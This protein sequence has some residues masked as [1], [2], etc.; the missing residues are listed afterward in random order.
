MAR[1][2]SLCQCPEMVVVPAGSFTMG[3]PESEKDRHHE[4]GPQH[5]VT[6][7]KSFAVGRCAV[8]FDEWDA[9]VGDGGCIGYKPGDE[10]W[11]RDR[12]PVINVS[13]ND[14]KTYVA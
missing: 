12:R 6:I 14:A 8:M 9:C 13:W 2:Q 3:S 1:V 4:E 5:A 11:G 7:G 10:G